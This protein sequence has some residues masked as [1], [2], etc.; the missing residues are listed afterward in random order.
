MSAKQKIA[1][2][3]RTLGRSSDSIG[4]D[5]VAEYLS[6]IQRNDA[7]LDVCIFCDEICRNTY[8]NI[9]ARDTSKLTDWIA[10]AAEPVVIYHWRDGWAAFD[11]AFTALPGRKIVRW[12]NNTPPWFF[13]PY[14]TLAAANTVRGL[15]NIRRLIVG[16]TVEFWANSAYSARQLCALGAPAQRVHV[17]YPLSPLLLAPSTAP[18]EPEA[19]VMPEFI[20]PANDSDA[21]AIRLLF[22]GRFVP[23]KGHRHLVATA[24]LVQHL[25]GRRVELHCVG[26]ADR[27]MQRYVDD[28]KRL[29]TR[30]DVDFTDHGEVPV[31]MLDH[32][33]A[34]S[35]VFLFM[36]EHKGF[37][38]PV[39]EA[40]RYGLPVV[41]VRSTA[42]AEF[43]DQH[44]LA[45]SRTDH[46]ALARAV[47]AAIQPHVRTAVVRW[48]RRAVLSAYS[49]DVVDAQI[50]GGIAGDNSI[51]PLTRPAD[52][53]LH[54]MVAATLATLPDGANFPPE[55]AA[56]MREIPA[57]AP[58]RMMTLYDIEA[59]STLLRTVEGATG[60]N[61]YKATWRTGF[62][63][64]RHFA[65]RV[66]RQ[67]R[68]TILSLNFGLVAS[69][70]QARQ[71]TGAQLDR[72]TDDVAMLREQNALILARLKAWPADRDTQVDLAAARAAPARGPAPLLQSVP[73]E[74]EQ[75]SSRIA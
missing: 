48:Q 11:D 71:Q 15:V 31:A 14:S 46:A 66:Y 44:P 62:P 24:A 39:I 73:N 43:L 34:T 22:V 2:V 21:R 5:C 33:Y 23:H 50:R 42:V 12:H 45:V 9:R 68:R 1:L 16:S 17:V 60:G 41:G 75:A 63:A 40:M 6:L 65:S 61:L 19:P 3:V 4:Y 38:L 20:R 54:A 13:A 26:R 32:L 52:A 35:D 69:I 25:S 10:D 36:S 74:V 58:D 37:G 18:L 7:S 53:A 47:I 72:L 64:K 49:G 56:I 30:L 57:D 70:D 28:V 8:D 59:Y 29:A 55:R 51:A 27:A 67:I